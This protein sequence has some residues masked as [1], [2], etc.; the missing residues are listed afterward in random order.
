MKCIFD[1]NGTCARLNMPVVKNCKCPMYATS[2]E[3]CGFCG[4]P[5]FQGGI[6]DSVSGMLFCDK[7]GHQL[8]KCPTCETAQ[9]CAFETDPS[10]VP[11]M[12]QQ[13]VRQGNMISSFPV[14]N[15]KRAEITCKNGCKC[16]D[17]EKGCLREFSTCANWK[18][19]GNN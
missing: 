9:T 5:I 10:P 15:P 13:T 14:K 8:N 18:L 1:Q 12:V 7:C 11:K 4:Q 2:Y 19:R 16:F 17:T 6:I 3:V